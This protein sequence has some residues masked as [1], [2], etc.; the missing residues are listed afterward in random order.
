M[1]KKEE[2]SDFSLIWLETG[3]KINNLKMR[4][5]KQNDKNKGWF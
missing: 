2:F 4:K 3:I 5:N 1:V